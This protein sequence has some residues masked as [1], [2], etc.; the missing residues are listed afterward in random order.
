MAVASA[1]PQR[2]PVLIFSLL[3]SFLVVKTLLQDLS[4][5]EGVV[6]VGAIDDSCL[7]YLL[8]TVASWKH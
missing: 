7:D 5:T 1:A 6:V 2:G 4:S 3:V 8:I